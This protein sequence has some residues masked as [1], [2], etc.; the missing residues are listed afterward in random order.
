MLAENCL[1]KSVKKNDVV[2]QDVAAIMLKEIN[3]S[4]V[5]KIVLKERTSFK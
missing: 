2:S 4:E 3:F 1:V 5:K